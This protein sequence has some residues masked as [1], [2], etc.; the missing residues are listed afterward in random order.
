M[1]PI[2]YK[3]VLAVDKALVNGLGLFNW[4]QGLCL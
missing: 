4:L 2:L 1:V 3:V